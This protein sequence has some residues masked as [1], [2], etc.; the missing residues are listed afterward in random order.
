MEERRGDELDPEIQE[1]VKRMYVHRYTGEH[2]PKWV[3]RQEQRDGVP[4]PLHFK[5]DLDW[6]VHTWFW[7]TVA[8]ELA[9][10]RPYCRSYPTWPHHP[11]LRKYA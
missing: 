1:Q 6:L 2:T 10:N 3:V 8:G 9:R 5:D 11:E 4:V 7:V